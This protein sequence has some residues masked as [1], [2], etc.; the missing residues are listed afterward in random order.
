LTAFVVDA[1]V[2]I[3]WFLPEIHSEA[4]SRVLRSKR[5]L[6]APDL[7]WA[8]VGNT[9]W[10]K[11]RRNEITAEEA[12]GILRDFIRFPL[13]TYASKTL[14]PAAWELADQFGITVYDSLYLALV[15]GRGRSLV[16]ADRKFYE[17]IHKKP[18]G[19]RVVWVEDMK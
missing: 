15:S 11:V 1:S 13:R 3:K 5:A 7:V 14:L 4:A 19:S 6:L 16:T 10:K 17:S 18:I 12:Y 8:E 2:A 9:L